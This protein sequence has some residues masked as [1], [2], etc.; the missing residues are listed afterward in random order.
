MIVSGWTIRR[1]RSY[2]MDQNAPGVATVTLI[3]TT[4]ELD[5]S[6]SSYAFTP[7]TPGAIAL[8]NPVTSTDATV[9]R[10]F[11]TRLAYDLYPTEDYAV[12]TLEMVDGLD[13]L[14]KM[15]MFGGEGWGSVWGD[16][17]R[18]G[19]DGDVSFFAD[20][21]SNAVAN[22]I[23]QIL[24]QADWPGGLRE[25]FSGNVSLLAGLYAYRTPALAA[26]LDAADAE[27]PGGV[28]R[29]YLQKDG[30]ATFHGRLARFFPDVAEYHISKWRSGDAAAVLAD[31]TRAPIFALDY[32]VDGGKV[33][34]SALSTPRGIPDDLIDAQRVEDTA[35]I[36]DFGTQAVSFDDL[37][38]AGDPD[39]GLGYG[40]TPFAPLATKKFSE[41]Y[42]DNRAQ[43]A[44]R[45]NRVRFRSLPSDAPGAARVWAVLCGCDISDIIRLKT[46]H[47]VGG[48]DEDLYVEGL[49]YTATSRGG[50]QMT[51]VQ[52][53]LDVSPRAYYDTNPF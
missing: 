41:Y 25:I 32:D 39:V 10:G 6:G 49:S 28:S 21:Q 2:E 48:F 23:N 50:S 43:P 18:I 36:A 7:G 31:S 29:F 20:D 47:Q 38:T 15:Q 35:S 16:F 1:G 24:N 37:L 4:G 44:T 5:P 11:V 51:D 42:V 34:N 27:F 12:A 46:T 17:P 40:Y 52:L 45:I 30:R 26:L 22:R 53:D 9:F 8:H 3:D 19:Q 33:I 13:R 14:A